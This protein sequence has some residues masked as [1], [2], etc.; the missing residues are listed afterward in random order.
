[1]KFVISIAT[2]GNDLYVGLVRFLAEQVRRHDARLVFGECSW[3]A[4]FAWQY[5]ADQLMPMDF[6]LCLMVDADVAPPM[7]ALEKL[8]AVNRDIVSAPVWHWSS[9]DLH[10]NLHFNNLHIREHA[11][12]TSGIDEII[13]TSFACVMVSRKVFDAFAAR[14]EKLFF[15]SALI[16]GAD[17]HGGI[18][19]H[20]FWSK[21]KVLGFKMWMCWDVHGA[22]HY[23]PVALNDNNIRQIREVT[24]K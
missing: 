16:S 22:T 23:R 12:R 9:G 2:R 18:P 11:A 7:D 8:S 10:L 5:A 3:S 21:A 6:D 4:Q 24:T 20:I 13:A 1:M 14:G 17:T 19:D 15:P